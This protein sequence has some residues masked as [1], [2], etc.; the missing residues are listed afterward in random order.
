MK[1]FLSTKGLSMSQAQ[2]ISNI[3]YQRSVEIDNLIVVINNVSKSITIG[4][5]EYIETAACPIPTN[6]TAL[7]L[8]KSRLSATQ[9]FLMENIKSKKELLE[10]LQ[11]SQ[12]DERMFILANPSPQQPSRVMTTMSEAV[13]ESWGWDQLSSEEYAEY[14]EVEAYAAHIGKF[15]HRGGKL[16]N[17]RLD[18]PTIKTLE[19]E[20]VEDGKKIP[21]IVK[22]HHT[23]S[24]LTSLYEEL[25][26]MHRKYEQ[27]VNYYKAKVKNL[28]SLEN[29]RINKENV[30]KLAAFQKVRDEE[31]AIWS[32]AYNKWLNQ[33]EEEIQKFEASLEDLKKD[34]VG[35][36]ISVPE[37][38]KPVIDEIL[39]TIGVSKE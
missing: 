21:K 35:L 39:N 33:K 28:T 30:I 23:A 19:W 34:I 6:I 29:A 9:A 22:I 11:S 27:K 37:R 4:N 5:T 36:R 14:L 26:G 38:F 17:L 18:L 1:K 13:N 3:C 15:I 10:D 8:E 25:A 20:S 31:N 2:S 24:V 7:L 32:N 16:T 12:F